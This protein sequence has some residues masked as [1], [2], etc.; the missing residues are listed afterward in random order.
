MKKIMIAAA[1]ALVTAACA[2]KESLHDTFAR[3]DD[4]VKQNS[5]AYSTLKEA[6]STIGHRLTGSENGH[7]A[8][9]YVFNKF[10]E[11]G[12]EDVKYMDFEVEAW[13]RGDISVE[14]DGKTVPAVALGHSPVSTD[15]VGE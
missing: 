2:K 14:V 4:E 5:K 8:E 9:E 10:K 13:S 3:I 15:L 6:T 7:K 12:F 1:I 11:Y